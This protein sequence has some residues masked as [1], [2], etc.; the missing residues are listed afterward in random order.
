M[1]GLDTMMEHIPGSLVMN[2]DKGEKMEYTD[3]RR[4]KMPML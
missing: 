1:S 4:K 2:R 3:G